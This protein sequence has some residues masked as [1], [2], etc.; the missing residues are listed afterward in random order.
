MSHESSSCQSFKV[1]FLAGT[2]A[3]RRCT[4]Q[5]ANNSKSKLNRWELKLNANLP[6]ICLDPTCS[7][8]SSYAIIIP[9]CCLISSIV[10]GSPVAP[11]RR[12]IP[13]LPRVAP[14]RWRGTRGRFE[15]GD[16]TKPLIVA[17]QLSLFIL[18]TTYSNLSATNKAPG[19]L[20]LN[21]NA[22]PQ[23]P[24]SHPHPLPS[25]P[26]CDSAQVAHDLP[27]IRS[28]NLRAN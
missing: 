16:S 27:S 26:R 3:S 22:G 9:P 11:A 13:F 28:I 20:P 18:A 7:K 5:R 17:D 4:S 10:T 19:L 23:V 8:W 24:Q 21:L 2:R 1:F 12:C 15:G 14:T 25:R 6:Q